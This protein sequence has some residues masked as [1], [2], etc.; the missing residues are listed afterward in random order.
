MHI[1]CNIIHIFNNTDIAKKYKKIKVL[2][3][4]L[5]NVIQLCKTLIYQYTDVANMGNYWPPKNLDS[6]VDNCKGENL[7]KGVI[8]NRIRL[9]PFLIAEHFNYLV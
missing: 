4:D 7:L 9:S 6:F 8:G 3:K 2:C 1:L 5:E